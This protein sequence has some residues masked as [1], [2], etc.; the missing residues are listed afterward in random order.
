[1]NAIV[2][3][4]FLT[5]ELNIKTNIV[6]S[7]NYDLEQKLIQ[8]WADGVTASE[9]GRQLG[10][11][12]DAVIGRVHRL[13]LPG[14]PH[15]VK[16]RVQIYNPTPPKSAK[17]AVAPSEQAPPIKL[18]RLPKPAEIPVMDPP[19]LVSVKPLAPS[20]REKPMPESIQCQVVMP[21]PVIGSPPINSC[22]WPM[23]G[24]RERPN[25]TYCGAARR[26]GAYCNEHGARAYTRTGRQDAAS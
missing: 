10:T 18:L 2:T 5:K 22:C 8:L 15:P 20:L 26:R 12:K 25:H 4:T 11:T 9:I 16:N 7:K 19:T 17:P 23:W 13:G 21:S 6:W 1:M 24:D 14:R 3:H